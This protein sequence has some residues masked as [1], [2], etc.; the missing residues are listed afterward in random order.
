MQDAV[1]A[2]GPKD[3]PVSPSYP[4]GFCAV[5][6]AQLKWDITTRLPLETGLRGQPEHGSTCAAVWVYG[7]ILASALHGQSEP[8]RNEVLPSKVKTSFLTFVLRPVRVVALLLVPMRHGAMLDRWSQWDRGS[9]S[10]QSAIEP[11]RPS[12]FLHLSCSIL[13]V[14]ALPG[15]VHRPTD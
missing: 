3:P 4:S 11:A 12:D 6:L 13:G 5:Y 1:N 2:L 15:Y 14:T 8:C 9:A 7:Q 10:T